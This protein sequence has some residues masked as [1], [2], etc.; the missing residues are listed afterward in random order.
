[1]YEWLE[2]VEAGGL[3]SYGPSLAEVNTAWQPTWIG[4]EGR[5]AAELPV[6][7]PTRFDRRST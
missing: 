3:L 6:E 7:R 1:M 2:I 5:Q 4:S